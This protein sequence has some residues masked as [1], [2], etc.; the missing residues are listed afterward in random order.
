MQVSNNYNLV[1]VYMCYHKL[2]MLC[3]VLAMIILTFSDSNAEAT[4][5]S[6]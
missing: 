4:Q 2:E 6:V 5:N 3:L 1:F